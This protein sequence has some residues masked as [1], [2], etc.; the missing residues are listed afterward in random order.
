MYSHVQ[1][2]S[3]VSPEAKTEAEAYWKSKKMIAAIT[4]PPGSAAA[5]GEGDGWRS[6][7]RSPSLSPPSA[8]RNKTARKR[9]EY[10]AFGNRFRHNIDTHSRLIAEFISVCKVPFN[11]INSTKFRRIQEFYLVTPERT[12]TSGLVVHP[13]KIHVEMLPL[14]YNEAVVR[15]RARIG[16]S[17]LC[18]QFIVAD[19]GWSSRRK[20]HYTTVTIGAPR[21]PPETVALFRILPSE[22]HGLGI[23]KGWEQ[24]ILLGGRAAPLED[25]P[26]GFAVPL[27][28]SP[29]AFVSDSSGPNVRAGAIASLRHP[30]IIFIPCLALILALLCGDY[31]MGSGRS[32]DIAKSQQLDHFFNSSSSLW[33]LLL[34]AEVSLTLGTSLS[35]V[36]AVETRW[37]STWLSVVPVLQIRGALLFVFTSS[38]GKE[39]A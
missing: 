38:A 30:N 15:S 25:Y 19:D 17:L 34:R 1:K 35:L 14:R 10:A 26:S 18:E 2:C 31:L 21:V 13:A 33:L 16:A 5:S 24:L 9:G 29:C 4:T 37:T 6:T 11:I 23:A 22:L 7:A 36:S 12:I 8:K 28:G 27:P 3:L 20:V 39:R 32:A